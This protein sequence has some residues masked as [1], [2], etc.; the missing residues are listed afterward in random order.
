MPTP[1]PRHAHVVP[2]QLLRGDYGGLRNATERAEEILARAPRAA[3]E[4]SAI[5]LGARACVSY[6]RPVPTARMLA[7]FVA[8]HFGGAAVAPVAVGGEDGCVLFGPR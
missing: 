1:C 3:R 6:E 4:S 2:L 5:I 7:R 8:S